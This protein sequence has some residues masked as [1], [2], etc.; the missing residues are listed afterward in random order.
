[1]LNQTDGRLIY[2]IFEDSESS[3]REKANTALKT[4]KAAFP[5]ASFFLPLRVIKKN[6]QKIL[7]N[8]KK[9]KI[10]NCE[11]IFVKNTH[12]ICNNKN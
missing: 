4:F 11:Q 1:M 8:K 10:S 12:L 2:F 9:T 6:S 7:V 3:V 5:I